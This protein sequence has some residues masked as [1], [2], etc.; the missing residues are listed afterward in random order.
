[1]KQILERIRADMKA[2]PPEVKANWD[3]I[4]H[5]IMTKMEG[6][7]DKMDS[8]QERTDANLEEIKATIRS[9]QKETTKALT[10][11][12]REATEAC[13]QKTKALPE[14]TEAC[15]V[16]TRACLDKESA[17]EATEVV[18]ESRE[19]LEGA[20]DEEAFGA[21][22]DRAGERRPAVGSWIMLYEE[23]L[24]DGYARRGEGRAR[25]AT[26]AYGD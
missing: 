17:L 12:C 2:I 16:K 24:K 22:D 25:N 23:P 19:V 3:A 10:G 26:V 1:M 11:A 20:T 8:N 4:A 13:E 18:E 6:N 14:T 15:P 9:G 5:K 21:T 7:Q